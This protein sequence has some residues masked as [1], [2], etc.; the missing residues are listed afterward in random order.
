MRYTVTEKKNQ[1]KFWK[2]KEIQ[3]VEEQKKE[4]NK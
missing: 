3:E 4:S 2:F 1:M